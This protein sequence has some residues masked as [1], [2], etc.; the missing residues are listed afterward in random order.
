MCKSS[1]CNVYKKGD[2]IARHCAFGSL[3]VSWG[4]E[5]PACE[6]IGPER[7]ATT[8]TGDINLLNATFTK[9]GE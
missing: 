8:V 5:L 2:A 6:P 7:H 9:N 3:A 4:R 1:R